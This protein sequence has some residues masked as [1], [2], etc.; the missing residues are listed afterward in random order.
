MEGESDMV[1]PLNSKEH[2]HSLSFCVSKED[3]RQADH[4]ENGFQK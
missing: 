4:V 1:N 3:G 2:L